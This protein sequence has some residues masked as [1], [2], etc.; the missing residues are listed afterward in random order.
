MSGDEKKQLII[1]LERE[2]KEAKEKEEKI[3][4]KLMIS[5]K[6]IKQIF[7]VDFF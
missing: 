1:E 5:N 2:E 7:P 6:K 3:R 4:K